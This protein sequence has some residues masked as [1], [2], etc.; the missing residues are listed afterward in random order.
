MCEV[1]LKYIEP[2]GRGNDLK[3]AIILIIIFGLQALQWWLSY[4]IFAWKTE[5]MLR[6]GPD[7]LLVLQQLKL[8]SAPLK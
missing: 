6:P 1:S 7:S 4:T 2:N 5:N 3:I 8:K